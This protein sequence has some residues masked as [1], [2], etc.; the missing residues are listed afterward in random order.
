MQE[1]EH[2]TRGADSLRIPHSQR[3]AKGVVAVAI[4]A[5]VAAAA[6]GGFAF[7]VERAPE[8]IE[9]TEAAQIVHTGDVV[10]V[11][12]IIDEAYETDLP[13]A[14]ALEAYLT[15][16]DVAKEEFL[17][18]DP[19]LLKAIDEDVA[20][21][22]KAV[23]LAL[24]GETV[25]PDD[26]DWPN[27]PDIDVPDTDKPGSTET[28]SD[29]DGQDG[30]DADAA[31]SDP[32][33]PSAPSDD[34]SDATLPDAVTPES[35]AEVVSGLQ[36]SVDATVSSPHPQWS[37][38]GDTTYTPHNVGVSL[39]TEKFIAVIGEQAREIAQENDL[40]ASVMIAQAILESASGNS[41]LSQ[42]PTYNLFGM[43]GSYDSDSVFMRTFEDDGNGSLFA[44]GAEFRSYPS[45]YASLADYA[46]LLSDGLD[47]YYEPVHKSNAKNYADACDF[48]EGTY[49]TDTS[50]SEKLQDLIVTYDL[51]RY[52]EPL[53]F[54][55]V[56][57]YEMPAVDPV[58][59]EA[60]IDPL[61]GTQASE[62]RDL[63]D[64]VREITSHLGV[65]YAWGSDDPDEGFDCSGL[66]EYSY[67]SALGIQ[68]PR[69]SYDMALEGTDV[70]FNDLVMGDL[71]FFTNDEG[72]A[73][74]VAVYLGEGCYIES[75][76]EG[77]V[78]KVT[79]MEEQMPDFA[80]RVVPL[81]PADTALDSGKVASLLSPKDVAHRAA[82]SAVAA[83]ADAMRNVETIFNELALNLI[84]K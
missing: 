50:Y 22:V 39:T 46:K 77:D 11:Q 30:G 19:L 29:P 74:H 15:G 35:T 5:S 66:V 6:P 25:S 51:T 76:A 1:K 44:T 2:A 37:Y 26:P 79:S 8:S 67:R 16:H 73:Y 32:A 31:P 60:V 71:L 70:D 53:S 45:V 62:K 12:T 48:L 83:I 7:A 80:K 84:S 59:G 40:Y 17:A 64:L 38:Q 9:A 4:A 78:V 57:D 42:A 49:A 3:F 55:T 36:A 27:L 21:E 18:I 61:T 54:Q 43:K 28:P 24:L 10:D 58:T 20:V 63:V 82:S 75:P 65:E 33:T 72:E 47:G 23:Q 52:D 14:S 13:G 41:E 68:L 56:L 81:E 69:T 34:V